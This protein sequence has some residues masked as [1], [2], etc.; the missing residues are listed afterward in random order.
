MS[1][2][3][4]PIAVLKP[5]KDNP[6]VIDDH[7]MT[8]LKTS[9]TDFPEMLKVRP[10]IIDEDKVI[11]AGNM[12]YQACMELGHTEVWCDLVRGLSK[13]KKME[14]IVKDNLTYGSWDDEV[15]DTHF[16]NGLM[17]RW[18]GQANI[19]YS[20]LDDFVN[21]DD[22][23]E[24]RATDVVRSIQFHLPNDFYAVKDMEK[25]LREAGVYIGGLVLSAL[26]EQLNAKG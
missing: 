25:E 12:R 14:F 2:K 17:E 13:E 22:E 9:I 3:R 23:L 1:V 8:T 24:Q 19:D 21:V 6:R 11:L 15:I 20:F 10:I 7:Q 26:K 18:T 5:H 16:D 4:Y